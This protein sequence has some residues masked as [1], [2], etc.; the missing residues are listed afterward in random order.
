MGEAGLALHWHPG[1]EIYVDFKL[2]RESKK[3]EDPF[4]L[5]IYDIDEQIQERRMDLAR[6]KRELYNAERHLIE[7]EQEL[8]TTTDETTTHALLFDKAY[9][10]QEIYNCKKII[11]YLKNVLE[12]RKIYR[13][14]SKE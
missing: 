11:Q 8:L 14:L 7:I 10:V 13:S 3:I 12:Y 2:G 5:R 6:R 9:K 4:L 1:Y